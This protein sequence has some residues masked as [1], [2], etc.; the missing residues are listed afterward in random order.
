MPDHC[1]VCAPV[2]AAMDAYAVATTPI[3]RVALACY[4]DLQRTTLSLEDHD[5]ALARAVQGFLV[6][7]VCASARTFLDQALSNL[8][9]A[10]TER[11]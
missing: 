8:D 7:H 10:L 3:V 4:V 2:R 5:P 1:A 11:A 9:Q 6:R